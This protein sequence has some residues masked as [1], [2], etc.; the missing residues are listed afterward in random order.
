[1]CKPFNVKVLPPAFPMLEISLIEVMPGIIHACELSKITPHTTVL[2]TG[3]GV[4][5][6]VMTQASGGTRSA[7]PAPSPCQWRLQVAAL[8]SPKA[9]VVTDLKPRNLELARRCE[10]WRQGRRGASPRTPPAPTQTARPIRTSS[11][12]STRRRWRRSAAT[13]PAASRS[14]FRACSTGTGCLTRSIASPLGAASSCMGASVRAAPCCSS[15][16]KRLHCRAARANLACLL[17]STAVGQGPAHLST[18]SRCIASG[19]RSI[20]RSPDATWTCAR[21]LS[22][23]R[24]WSAKVGCWFTRRGHVLCE[25]LH[26]PISPPPSQAS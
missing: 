12:T 17:L 8:Y 1:M 23:A 21:T 25:S 22:R 16:R 15:P 13:S 4:S 18:S 20:Q 7:A 2:I 9:L 26:S 19:R 6:L 10:W 11:L 14:S 3:Q 5:G 24:A